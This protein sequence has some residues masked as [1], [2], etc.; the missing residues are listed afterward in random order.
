MPRVVLRLAWLRALNP[1]VGP[2]LGAVTAPRVNAPIAT[3]LADD[4]VGVVP[5]LGEVLRA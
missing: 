4:S 5:V 1:P 2:A 3:S